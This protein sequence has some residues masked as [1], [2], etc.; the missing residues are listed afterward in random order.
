[1]VG[2]Y[3]TK[4]LQG[5]LFNK[6]RDRILNIQTDPPDVPTEDHRSVLGR[7]HLH[8]T[9]QSHGQ[10]LP[11]QSCATAQADQ[12]QG[13][14]KTHEMVARAGRQLDNEPNVH[15]VMVPMAQPIGGWHVTSMTGR[16]RSTLPKTMSPGDKEQAIV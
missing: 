6:F 13:T 4:P 14:K 2:D 7:D 11:V 5:G 10:S 16:S 8:A 1:M 3:F 9:G 12:T 15:A